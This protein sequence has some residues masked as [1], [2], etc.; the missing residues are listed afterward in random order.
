MN[1][2]GLTFNSRK[3]LMNNIGESAGTEIANLISEMA[4]EIDELRRTK[5]SVTKIVPGAEEL[6]HSQSQARI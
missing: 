4:S 1:R 2:Q 6:Q 5:V 3:A